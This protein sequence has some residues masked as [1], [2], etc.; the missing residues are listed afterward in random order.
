LIGTKNIFNKN[1]LQ[2]NFILGIQDNLSLGP[3]M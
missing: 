3:V 1:I 2:F